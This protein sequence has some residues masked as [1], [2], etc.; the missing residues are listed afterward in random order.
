M[1]A[2]CKPVIGLVGGIGAGKSAAAAAMARRGGRVVDG[3]R[4]GH[5]AL[6]LPDVKRQLVERWGKRV[7][8]PN[9]AANRRA[10]AGIVF[11][12]PAELKALEAMVFPH[13]GRRARDE[14]AVAQADPVVRFVV[15]DAA[16]ML[17]AGWAD[18]CDRIVYV[19]ASRGVRLAR[20]AARSGWTPDEV[21]AR[22]AAQLAPE[23][24]RA[25]ADAVLVNDGT[26]GELQ[27]YV[28]R[29]LGEWGLLP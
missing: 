28:D 23:A 3:D 4:L 21:A 8:K 29:L 5:E 9:G 26:P 18:A 25:H 15:L 2:P 27:E 14:I 1:T 16:V 12:A 19:D 11:D 22:E 10:I 7:L 24:K 17:E 6:E 20:L 13:I